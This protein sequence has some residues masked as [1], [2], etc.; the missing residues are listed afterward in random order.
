MRR[1]VCQQR[2]VPNHGGEGD[3][4]RYGQEYAADYVFMRYVRLFGRVGLHHWATGQE[5]SERVYIHSDT[6][7]D[8]PLRVESTAG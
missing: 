5:R 1:N 2:H 4:L 8:G 7:R 3:E 6:Q